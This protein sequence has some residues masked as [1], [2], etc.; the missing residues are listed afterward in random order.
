MFEFTTQTVLNQLKLFTV[1]G[2]D[3]AQS[4]SESNVIISSDPK[5][6]LRIAN[7][8]FNADDVESVQ[9]KKA[10]A[11]HKTKVTFDLANIETVVESLEDTLPGLYRIALYVGLSMNSHDSYYANAFTYK[12]KPMYIEFTIGPNEEMADVAAKIVRIANKYMLFT[13]DEKI[14]N[15]TADDTEVT[16]EG[17]NFYQ[18]IKKAVLQKYDPSAVQI[19]CCSTEGDFIALI[20]GVP[21]TWTTSDGEIVPGETKFVDGDKVALTANVEVGIEPGIEAFGDYNWMIHNLRLPTLANTN[22]FSPTKSEMPAVGATYDQ[23]II[24]LCTQ[25]DHVA[26]EAVGMRVTSVTNHVFYVNSADS[27]LSDFDTAVK[28]LVD[29]EKTDADNAFADPFL[30]SAGSG[31]EQG[32]NGGNGQGGNGG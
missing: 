19:D 16:F 1:G 24:T 29:A 21:L 2:D 8:R 5:P 13:A 12:G 31:N 32:G 15:V 4:A 6:E 17:T 27:N 25:R 10:T 30:T 26:G 28:A 14:L 7:F 11:G 18:Q 3:N 22:F 23:Y 20:D 9:I